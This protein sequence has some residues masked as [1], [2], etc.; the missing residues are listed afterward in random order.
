VVDEVGYLTYGTDAANMLFHVVNDRHKRKRSMIFTTNKP[1][2]AWGR[3]LHDEDLA[4]AIVDRVLERGRLLHLDGPSMR[5]KHLGLDDPT[6]PEAPSEQVVRISGIQRSELP[7]PTV[8]RRARS[9]L[10]RRLPRQSAHEQVR[11]RVH[12]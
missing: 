5:T 4:Q 7:E 1:L 12:R 3:V 9:L 2:A 10:R 8:G 6:A 11:Q